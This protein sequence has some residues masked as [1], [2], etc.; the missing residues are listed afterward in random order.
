[1]FLIHK[2]Q[3]CCKF[4][5]QQELPY[6]YKVTIEFCLQLWVHYLECMLSTEVRQGKNLVAFLFFNSKL[7]EFCIG[8]CKQSHL[9]HL[10]SLEFSIRYQEY[11]SIH[12]SF[13]YSSIFLLERLYKT[14]E[15]HLI[16]FSLRDAIL[17]LSWTKLLILNL[18][19]SEKLSQRF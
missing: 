14:R 3:R 6:P 12:C 1:M 9:L 4:L 18:H 16:L 15:R 19:T 7:R 13:P 11:Q 2:A 17:D 10:S 5:F 8:N